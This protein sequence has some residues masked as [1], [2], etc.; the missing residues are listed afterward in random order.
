MAETAKK[1]EDIPTVGSAT[2]QKL[3]VAGYN[4]VESVAVASSKELADATGISRDRAIEM[5]TKAREML[6]IQFHTAEE[7]LGMRESITR[8]ITGSKALDTLL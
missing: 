2:A 8:L 1:L 5:S 3:R 6:Q 4:T 7:L